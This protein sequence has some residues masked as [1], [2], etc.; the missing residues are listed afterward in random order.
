MCGVLLDEALAHGI[1]KNSTK[2]AYGSCGC[3]ETS[4]HNGLA[5]LLA[6]L[7]DRCSS[8]TR[9]VFNELV[10]VRGFE[11]LHTLLAEQRHDVAIDASAIDIQ[12]ACLFRP[13]PFS[14]DEALLCCC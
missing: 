1:S 3:T 14:K 9:N 2:K 4:P 13:I 12:G 8:S 6:C 7:L 5:S 10:D 11:S